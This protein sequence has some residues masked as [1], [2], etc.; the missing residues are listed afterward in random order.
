MAAGSADWAAGL[1]NAAEDAERRA[2]DC[3]SARQPFPFFYGWNFQHAVLEIQ[4]R[5]VAG[6]D[7]R[8]RRRGALSP[9][10]GSKRRERGEDQCLWVFG[11]DGKSGGIASGDGQIQI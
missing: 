4:R 5:R 1:S 3:L 11:G 7:Y 9:S 6:M 8:H 2:Q 10:S